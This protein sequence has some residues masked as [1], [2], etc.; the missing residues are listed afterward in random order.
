MID[1]KLLRASPEE[2]AANFARRGFRLD[3]AQ[4]TALEDRRKVAQ[5]EA[6]RLRAERNAVSKQVGMAKGR[7]EDTAAPCDRL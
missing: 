1:P 4:F 2:V 3:V 6:D 7:G 5:V